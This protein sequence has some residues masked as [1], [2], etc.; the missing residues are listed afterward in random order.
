MKQTLF[1]TI[2]A[3][4]IGI[5]MIGVVMFSMR[6][7]SLAVTTVDVIEVEPGVRCARTVTA[8]GA[9]ISCWVVPQ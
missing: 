1:L 5:L 2:G 8:D 4:L 7:F 9:A 6:Q 3:I